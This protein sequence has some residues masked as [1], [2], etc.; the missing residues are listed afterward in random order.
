[1]NR[2]SGG[3]RRD[4]DD[5]PSEGRPSESYEDAPPPNEHTRLLPNRL[6]GNPPPPHGYLSPDDPAVTPYNLFAVR[7]TRYLTVFFALITSVWWVLQLVSMFITPPGLFTRGSGFFGFSYASIALATLIVALLFFAQPSRAAR[8]LSAIMSVLL[9]AN[10]IIIIAVKK[11]RH[12]EAWTGIASV[13][14]ALLMSIWALLADQ[15]VNW[16]KKEE[17]ERLTGRPETRRT[18]LEWVQVLL[19]TIGFGVLAV[20]VLLLT[21]TLILRAVD[22][23]VAP[24]GDLYWVDGDKYQIHLYCHGNGTDFEGNRLPTVL[25]EGGEDPIEDG[26]WQFADNALK[27]GSFSRYCFA[28]RPGMA[29]VSIYSGKY[30]RNRPGLT[31]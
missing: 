30:G 14:W 8:V 27:N 22:A 21:L 3:R 10:M 13:I 31:T 9:L 2:A 15:T 28:D 26:L 7:F 16:G 6:E 19:A 17:E 11:A 29:W 1:M 23:K 5:S 18:L 4:G 24:P 12:E 20:V 25:F